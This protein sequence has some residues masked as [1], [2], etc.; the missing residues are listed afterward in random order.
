MNSTIRTSVSP[1][2]APVRLDEPAE[3][4]HPVRAE[5]DVAPEEPV[6]AGHYPGFPVFPG[7]CVLDLVHRTAVRAGPPGRGVRLNGVRSVKFG[8]AVYPGDHLTIELRWTE[9]TGREEPWSVS[10]SVHR[11]ELAVANMRLSYREE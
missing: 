2:T 4:G 3:L 7:V 9:P 10:A 1:V 8:A 6:F 5:V 11:A